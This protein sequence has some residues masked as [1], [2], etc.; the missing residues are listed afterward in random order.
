MVPN[1]VFYQTEL[2]TVIMAERL[3][4]EPREHF[5]SEVFKTSSFSHSLTS[6]ENKMINV[7]MAH[8]QGIEPCYSVLETDTS[9]L[10]AYGTTEMRGF[11]PPDHISTINGLANRHF[12]PLSHISSLFEYQN[13]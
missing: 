6:P 8:R 5:C 1:H 3:G 7:D 9:P 12:K 4:F 2:R 11:E 13:R 10:N